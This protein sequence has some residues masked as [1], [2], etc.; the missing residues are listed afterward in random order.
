MR[1]GLVQ[2]IAIS[3]SAMGMFGD[4]PFED[5]RTGEPLKQSQQGWGEMFQADTLRQLL[6]DL[7]E[8]ARQDI[9]PSRR[10]SGSSKQL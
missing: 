2:H 6:V 10:L 8:V 3:A 4:V 9:H 1:H 5:P 7:L